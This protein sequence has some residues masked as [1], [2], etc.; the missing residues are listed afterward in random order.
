[1][2]FRSCVT[3]LIVMCGACSD[4][5]ATET[6]TPFET[7]PGRA[8][9]DVT[10][11]EAPLQV[12]AEGETEPVNLAIDEPYVYWT[13]RTAVR[14]APLTGGAPTTLATG[15]GWGRIVAAKDGVFVTDQIG[16]KLHRIDRVSGA[17]E[18]IGAGEYPDG[19]AAHSG[20][21]Y[22]TNGA[23]TVGGG[24]V[25]AV[26]LDDERSSVLASGLAQPSGIAADEQF[27]YFTS[28]ASSCG[29]MGCVG[30]GVSKLPRTGGTVEVVDREGTPT[31]IIIGQRGIYWMIATPTKV[32]FANRARGPAQLLADASGE[33]PGPIEIDLGGR[34]AGVR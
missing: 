1:M 9:P 13:T 33:E 14:R 28:T 4:A 29:P 25:A 11:S 6:P 31:H 23:S 34:A 19:I 22:W 17:F 3:S 12:F 30:G 15:T 21:V 20:N 24:S 32:V 27:I 2:R 18:V 5:R 7:S 10:D 26:R 8:R 16:G